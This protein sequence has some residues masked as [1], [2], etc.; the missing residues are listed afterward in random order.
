M[1]CPGSRCKTAI[2]YK[3]ASVECVVSI[4]LGAPPFFRS[5]PY[6]LKINTTST[7]KMRLDCIDVS[8]HS[9]SFR[10]ATL[11]HYLRQACASNQQVLCLPYAH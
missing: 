1:I 5:P 8:H 4:A 7:L 11:D 3:R 9:V 2:S 10:P 6:L